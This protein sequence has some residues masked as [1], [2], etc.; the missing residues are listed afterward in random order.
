MKPKLP[1]DLQTAVN[2]AQ[3]AKKGYD[4]VQNINE[5]ANGGDKSALIEIK[6]PIDQNV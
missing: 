5:L 1:T 2:V 3:T 6:P 4:A